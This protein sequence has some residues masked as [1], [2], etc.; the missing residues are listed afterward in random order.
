[1]T[2]L[3]LEPV[4]GT[5]LDRAA[6]VVEDVTFF[7][8]GDGCFAEVGPDDV[9]R[10]VRALAYAGIDARASASDLSA[11]RDHLP[12]VARDLAPAPVG[13][14]ACDVVRVRR[15]SLGEATA[16]VLRRRLA[17]FRPPSAAAQ[18]RC[19]R[20]LSGDDALLAWDR[21][22]WVERARLRALRSR[23][24]LRP[25]VFDR[26]AVERDERRGRSFASDTA[27]ANWAFG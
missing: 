17:M 11:P 9:A 4:Q 13:L 22:A 1:M 21:H 10:M 16:E 2:L 26:G 3:R 23:S 27:L 24:S 25:V 14:V 6:A 19:R 20:L 12:A 8:R 5:A 15:L 18:A 7:R